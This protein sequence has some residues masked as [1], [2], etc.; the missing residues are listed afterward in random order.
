MVRAP[1]VET[2]LK[3][4]YREGRIAYFWFL[5][6]WETREKAVW[7]NDQIP[8]GPKD[9]FSKK[10]GN[11]HLYKIQVGLP[12]PLTERQDE[13]VIDLSMERVWDVTEKPIVSPDMWAHYI[14]RQFFFSASEALPKT[15]VRALTQAGCIAW[16]MASTGKQS[17]FSISC[18]EGKFRVT[19]EKLVEDIGD[20]EGP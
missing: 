9:V 17:S 11:T 18:P 15:T 2:G 3:P 14:G 1:I 16:N 8:K 6:D 4:P 7:E 5:Y 13:T 19:I 12:P 20:P 10:T